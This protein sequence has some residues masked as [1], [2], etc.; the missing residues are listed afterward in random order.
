MMLQQYYEKL[1]PDGSLDP[2][3][4][5]AESGVMAIS[6]VVGEPSKLSSQMLR[7]GLQRCRGHF[8]VVGCA[9]DT[10]DAL[11]QIKAYHPDIALVS[12]ALQDGAQ[13]GFKV[14]RELRA[15]RNST[16]VIMVMDR[17]EQDVVL[18]AFA[19][20]AKGVFFRT[21]GFDVLCKCIRCVHA[22]QVWAS[23]GQVQLIL[24]ALAERGPLSVLD[25]AGRPLLTKREEEIVRMVAEGL[26]NPQISSS[27]R[28]SPHTVKNHLFRIYEKLGVSNRVELVLY[29]F[30]SSRMTSQ[31]LSPAA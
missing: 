5:D 26:T 9:V 21:E 23:S 18:H 7:R 1:R 12:T 17:A 13:A 25:A 6:I 3:L 19:G 27:L 14:L 20:G 11:S 30:S 4:P 15:S 29:A 10:V 31:A 16:S 28:L 24:E 2:K 8:K 22:G